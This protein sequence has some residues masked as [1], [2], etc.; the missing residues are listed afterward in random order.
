[1]PK[2]VEEYAAKRTDYWQERR[3]D[4]CLV[5]Q[6]STINPASIMLGF[7]GRGF[8][9][10]PVS[11]VLSASRYHKF[12]PAN[13]GNGF[14]DFNA[15]LAL[16]INKF[17]AGEISHMAMLHGDVMAESGWLDI[18]MGEM[19]STGA[20][21]VSSVIPIKDNRGLTSCG[22]GEPS[23]HWGPWRRIT[24]HEAME[25]P[26][27]FG[28]DDL[29]ALG[30]D[31]SLGHYLLHNTGCWVADLS[32]PLFH[33]T[34]EDGGLKITFD[35]PT[36]VARHDDGQWRHYRESEDWYWS[37]ML[38]AAGAKTLITRKAPL[39]H[40]GTQ[41][42]PNTASWGSYEHDRDTAHNWAKPGEPGSN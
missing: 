1:V 12:I 41:G 31:A 25:L 39:H 40:M 21:V 23:N 34:N 35:F 10:G 27:T 20:D 7:P 22:I 3:V 8:D 17:E 4:T 14:D 28:L 33:E 2:A 38:H 29:A 42:Y 6:R 19:Q 13:N 16:A 18:L 11:G 9:W 5:M 24:M 36:R 26:E 32:K 37:R 30:A 15:L